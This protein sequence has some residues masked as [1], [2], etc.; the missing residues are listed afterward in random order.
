MRAILFSSGYDLTALVLRWT[1]AIA[2]FPHGAQKLL[3]IFG[4]YGYQ[5]TMKFFMENMKL[6]G[7]ISLL[8]IL[9]EFL[10]PVGLAVGLGTQVWAICFLLIM[11]AAVVTT[12][13]SNGFFMNWFNNQQGE[14]YEYHL[15]VMGLC[16]A[17]ILLGAGRWSLDQALSRQ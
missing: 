12:H 7:L 4:G 14:G 16:I 1:L 5:A 3:G 9:I 11:I 17:L 13:H 15:I 2:M 6:P 10:G 8:V